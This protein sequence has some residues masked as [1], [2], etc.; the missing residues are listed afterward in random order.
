MSRQPA[1]S[2]A[3]S[4]SQATA[5]NASVRKRSQ[6][7]QPIGPIHW[8]NPIGREA[9]HP[10]ASRGRQ[11]SPAGRQGARRVVASDR[12]SQVASDRK[13]LVVLICDHLYATVCFYWRMR[14]MMRSALRMLFF[15]L[16]SSKAMPSYLSSKKEGIELRCGGNSNACSIGEG[17]GRGW[18]A[19]P[20]PRKAEGNCLRGFCLVCILWN[21]YENLLANFFLQEVD[22]EPFLPY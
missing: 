22:R 14:H 4:G 17:A 11:R 1:R 9:T 19:S 7:S 10:Q 2:D 20:S 8:S 5:S 6:A 16:S 18:V 13:Q 15:L 12:K 3:R 21:K